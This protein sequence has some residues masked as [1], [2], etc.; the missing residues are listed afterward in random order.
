MVIDKIEHSSLERPSIVKRLY[1]YAVYTVLFALVFLGVF[2]TFLQQHKGFVQYGDGYRQGLFWVHELRDLIDSLLSGHLPDTWTWYGGLGRPTKTG[3]LLDPFLWVA[4]Y[5]TNSHP[6]LGYTIAVTLEMYCSGFAFLL[7][8]RKVNVDHLYGIM[9]ALCYSFSSWVLCTVMI[10]GSFINNTVLFP[11]VILGIEKIYR[12]ES[13]FLFMLVV[14][15]YCMR[16]PYFAYMAAI[17]AIVY[18]LLRYFHYHE[19]WQGRDYFLTM[20]KFFGYGFVGLLTSMVVFISNLIGIKGASTDSGILHDYLRF[21]DDY[22]ISII[23]SFIGTRTIS[24][25]YTFLGISFLIIFGLILAIRYFSFKNT[26]V[27]MTI[28]SFIMILIPVCNRLFN[29]MTYPTGRWM[30]MLVFFTVWAGTAALGQRDRLTRND[31]ILLAGIM[32]T[33][34]CY[35]GVVYKLKLTFFEGAEIKSIAIHSLFAIAFLLILAIEKRWFT[36]YATGWK[37][38]LMVTLCLSIVF[39]WGSKKTS[40]TDPFLQSHKLQKKLDRSVQ[41]VG[42]KIQDSDFYRVDQVQ[43]ISVENLLTKYANE[44]LWWKTKSIYTYDS[45]IPSALLEYNKLVGNNQDY[46]ERT[47]QFSNDN[48]AGLD[49]LQGVKYFLGDDSKWKSKSSNY[50]GYGFTHADT[51]DGVEI[52]KAKYHIGAGFGYSHCISEKEFRKL[53]RL[54]REQALL[55]AA[56]IPDKRV[57]A[58]K[59]ATKDN[60]ELMVTAKDIE[61][62][63]TKVPYTL[64]STDNVTIGQKKTLKVTKAG[65]TM[66]LYVGDVSNS[67]LFLSFDNLVKQQPHLID[68]YSETPFT[69]TAAAGNTEKAIMNKLGNQGIFGIIDFD[70]NLGY[71]DAYDGTITIT[72][73]DSGEYTYD[74]IYVSAMKKDVFDSYAPQCQNAKLKVKKYDSESI[75]GTVTMEKAG[76]LYYAVP[77]NRGWKI[78]VDGKKV[79]P[80]HGLNIAYVGTTVEKGRHNVR[81]EYHVPMVKPAGAISVLGLLLM[82]ALSTLQWRRNGR[83]RRLGRK[84]EEN[85]GI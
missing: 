76:L 7:F 9:G 67:Q 3:L 5:F 60:K 66:K 68:Q 4:A 77:D 48:R 70:V 15:Y 82:I 53:P 18:I 30:F 56:V 57:K 36:K 1:P 6:E 20:A 71:Y 27:V 29:G 55:Q 21:T 44:S 2:F 10:Q 69:I 42:N 19:E 63:I 73:K 72:F 33:M 75:T 49:L 81:L 47:N 28:L 34:V 58:V 32:V 40:E 25:N 8:L 17:M 74:D 24:D 14:A 61:A 41:R 35:V 37:V 85:T 43:G 50:A 83:K 16:M 13:P 11:L 51:I 62:S 84:S 26:P 23:Q 31:M 12:K 78:T 54:A 52:L 64:V 38:L 39:V 65:G 79:K 80:I 45:K 59:K 46:V 22:Y